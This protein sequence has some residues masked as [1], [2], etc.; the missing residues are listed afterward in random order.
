MT[1]KKQI[2]EAA[3]AMGRKGG[4]STS[5]A[6]LAAIAK[7]A[8]LGGRPIRN[9]A[10]AKIDFDAAVNLMDDEIREMLSD[11]GVTGKQAFLTRYEQEH[12]KKFGAEW[13]LSKANPVW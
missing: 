11:L 12:V 3:A 2:S 9:M 7:N 10:G 1:I 6:K 4:R 8:K 13:E 5:P